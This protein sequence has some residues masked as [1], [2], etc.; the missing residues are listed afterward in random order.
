MEALAGRISTVVS[1]RS[2]AMRRMVPAEMSRTVETAAGVANFCMVFLLLRGGLFVVPL[3]PTREKLRCVR[4]SGNDFVA[5]E[6]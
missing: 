3:F 1:V 6:T 4:G 5:L 2:A